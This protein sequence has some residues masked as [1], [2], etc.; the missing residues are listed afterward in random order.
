MPRGQESARL[1]HLDQYHSNVDARRASSQ[2]R[3]ALLSIASADPIGFLSNLLTIA[4]VVVV[5]VIVWRGLR[6]LMAAFRK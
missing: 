3:R 4:E 6:T 2:E 1:H 5:G